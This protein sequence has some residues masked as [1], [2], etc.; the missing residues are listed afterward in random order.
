[1]IYP[2]GSLSVCTTEP[3]SQL[4][5]V[6]KLPSIKLSSDNLVIG[7]TPTSA[8]AGLQC[9]RTRIFLRFYL[10][11]DQQLVPVHTG[12]LRTNHCF[13]RIPIPLIDEAPASNSIHY[14]KKERKKER[15]KEK[16]RESSPGLRPPMEGR[17]AFL[18]EPF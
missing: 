9:S 5:R 8:Q 2:G 6:C 14:Q 7:L 12:T 1:M 16:R 10:W 17:L 15:K 13:E 4:S 11:V 3:Q 18:D